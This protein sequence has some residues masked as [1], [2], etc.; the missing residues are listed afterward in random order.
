MSNHLNKSLLT[1]LNNNKIKSYP[2]TGYVHI[3][4]LILDSYTDMIK[5]QK[6]ETFLYNQEV[7]YN[8]TGNR[9]YGNNSSFYSVMNCHFSSM[10]T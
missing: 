9:N 1:L 8:K 4:P 6:Q 2:K 3:K 10:M 7:N 5:S